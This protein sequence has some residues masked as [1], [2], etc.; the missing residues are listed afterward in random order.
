MEKENLEDPELLI[1]KT[2]NAPIE[3]VWKAW[4]D[5][6]YVA[7]W[8]GP[9]GFTTTIIKMNVQEGEEWL[10]T[11]HGPDGKNYPNKSIFRE[12]IPFEKI[13]YEHFNPDFIATILFKPAG[14]DQTVLDWS[15][16][17]DTPEMFDIVVKT[18]KADEGHRENVTKLEAFLSTFSPGQV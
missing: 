12:V 4:T 8:W 2:F 5:P 16:R 9:A 17:F 6:G 13:V 7:Q 10:L 15:L 1:T 18:F 11:L 3:L 14:N